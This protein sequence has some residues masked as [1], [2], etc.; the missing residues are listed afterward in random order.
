LR[1]E[2]FN[3]AGKTVL[4]S[5]N[6]EVHRG[7]V[8][9]TETWS[10][11]KVHIVVGRMN[12]KDGASVTVEAGT[13]VKFAKNSWINTENGTTLTVG[14]NTT[15]TRL[16]DDTV[17]GD[18]NLDGGNSVPQFGNAYIRGNGN[19]ELGNVTMK[20]VTTT[21]SGTITQSETWYAGVYHVTGD[22]TVA[23]GATLTLMPG[24]I[25][26]FDPGCQ[27]TVNS[28][29]TLNAKG[30][31]VQPIVFTSVKDDS[32]GGDTN[33]DENE[34]EAAA[35]DWIGLWVY[36]LADMEHCILQYAGPSNERG[37][38]QVSS[39]GIANLN[40]C[41][42]AHAKYDGFWNWGG[43][44]DSKN[45]IIYDVGLATAPYRGTQT[46]TNCTFDSVS[47]FA[48]YWSHWT[49]KAEYTNCIFNNI[50]E[51]WIDNQE[52]NAYKNSLTFRNNVFGTQLAAFSEVGKNGNIWADP[53]FRDAA[54]G[55][56]HL[57][58]GS[59][60]I[61]AADGSVALKTDKSGIQRV[62][63]IY[64]T[65][66]GIAD[67]DGNY[68]DIGAFEFAEGTQG[69]IDLE[70]ISAAGPQSVSIG[71]KVTISWTLKNNGT[72][73]A[74]GVWTDSVYLV[75][76]G[77]QKVLASNVSH[78]GNITSGDLQTFYA[79]VTIPQIA[80]GNWYIAVEAN[81]S[82]SLFEG[83]LIENNNIVS[84]AATFVDVP[85]LTFPTE[86]I[87]LPA[88]E[89]KLYKVIIP[90]NEEYYLVCNTVQDDKSDYKIIGLTARDGF[91]PT[92]TLY[93]WKSST[94]VNGYTKT[95]ESN[96]QD[97]L[98]QLYIPAADHERTVYLD[99]TQLNGLDAAIFDIARIS[100]DFSLKRVDMA[101][102]SVDINDIPVSR[103]VSYASTV[104]VRVAGT[105]FKEGMTAAL[106]PG[107]RTCF[108]PIYGNIMLKEAPERP[109]IY[110]SKVNV[111][112]GCEA[113]LTFEM[114]A[115]GVHCDIND[116]YHL[117]LN[118]NGQSVQLEN[119][120]A[121]LSERTTEYINQKYFSLNA[122]LQIPDSVR[123]GRVYTGYINYSNRYMDSIAPLLIVQASSNVKL[124][125]DPNSWE[126]ASNSLQLL[127]I[128]NESEAGRLTTEDSGRIPFY[129]ITSS[130]TSD[131]DI[132]LGCLTYKDEEACL[133]TTYFTTWKEYHEA[134]AEAA[135]RLNL[136][137]KTYVDTL[138][139]YE[140]AVLMKQGMDANAISGTLTNELTGEAMANMSLTASW[141]D[142][143][144][145]SHSRVVTTDTEGFFSVEYLPNNVTVTMNCIGGTALSKTVFQVKNNDINKQKLTVRPTEAG[146]V[147]SVGTYGNVTAYIKYQ[148]GALTHNKAG[149]MV[150]VCTNTGSSAVNAPM[151]RLQVQNKA[152]KENALLTL[153]PNLAGKNYSVSV[154]PEGFANS[155]GIIVSGK[156]AGTIQPGETVEIPIYWGGLLR[157]WDSLGSEISLGVISANLEMEIDLKELEKSMRPDGIHDTVWNIIW[158]RFTS[159]IGT[160]WGSYVAALGQIQKGL[161]AN[162]NTVLDCA[163]L[164]QLLLAWA[165]DM[166]NPMGTLTS[167]LDSEV[168]NDSNSLTWERV[169][170]GG[171]LE[172]RFL[173]SEMGRGWYHN[174]DYSLTLED[175]GNVLLEF[176]QGIAIVY[177]VQKTANGKTIYY[178]Q[179]DVHLDLVKETDGTWTLTSQ[180]G[181]IYIFA[182]DGTL[183]KITD[184]NGN[185]ISMA[186]SEGKL[187]SV[188][189]FWGQSLTIERNA[190]GKITSVT[191]SNGRRTVYTYDKTNTYLISA[192]WHDGRTVSYEYETAAGNTLSVL[193]TIT[194][195]DGTH[196][197][198]T[199]DDL[200]RVYETHYDNGL[201]SVRYELGNTTADLLT[202]KVYS[203]SDLQGTV[204]L[205]SLGLT[206]KTVDAQGRTTVYL[207]DDKGQLIQSVAPDSTIT[208]YT[209]DEWGNLLSVTDAAGSLLG[210]TYTETGDLSTLTDA[211]GNKTL[212]VYDQFGNMTSMQRA[213]QTCTAYT[214]NDDGTVHTYT[215]R[216]G[217]TFVYSYTVSSRRITRNYMTAKVMLPSRSAKMSVWKAKRSLSPKL[218]SF[219]IPTNRS[220]RTSGKTPSTHS[221]RPLRSLKPLPIQTAV[222]LSCGAVT[223]HIPTLRIMN[224][225]F[226]ET[227]AS[228]NSF[229]VT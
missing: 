208:S 117:Q 200:G 229:R 56:H 8:T 183:S 142:A 155:L 191:E 211:A 51:N 207:Y 101:V 164:Q 37:L 206:A 44:I 20:F 49:G 160:T 104:S 35:G 131:E 85:T 63:D 59:P 193:K 69:N 19:F 60:C 36:G 212:F 167:S 143:Q 26:K 156:T 94:T 13:V 123:A 204:Y 1:V 175:N 133:D 224:S 161:A 24:V 34:T 74:K 28:G 170:A 71:D 141:T 22:L 159:I 107:L 98:T 157:P 138:K 114:P 132:S 152:G 149:E 41:T 18:T 39:N 174:W 68:A 126:D 209:Y 103:T 62:A 58:A 199:Y 31:N 150:L 196:Q 195:A 3:A 140:L 75:S 67:S 12:L 78:S 61:D 93:D 65:P 97:T 163:Q 154:L 146:M 6:V 9:E 83:S 48:M 116:H 168:R 134:L 82:R 192:A 128:G 64:S 125:L 147:Y 30:N 225:I 216:M 47:Y 55:D 17:G 120:I 185:I 86:S 23:S 201:G 180:D 130:D 222:S 115:L 186:Y 172:E 52:S 173:D 38:L 81:T 124:S 91:V 53:L 203:G 165:T 89:S 14:D 70:I 76:E 111:I 87:T 102:G 179:A 217:Q 226:P 158:S 220:R 100:S 219:L 228:W 16:E 33:E 21:T 189:D 90:A 121:A 129:F 40:S 119:S 190:A 127:G 144:G 73:A 171:M 205:N 46:F 197:Y 194:F 178:T 135:T 113:I 166:V 145:E 122:N 72:A 4:N 96:W 106:I 42:L 45:C 27:L 109:V 32:Y 80:S 202:Y 99:I 151:V 92:D 112:S 214:Y 10:K 2:Y 198:F 43:S 66:T 139:A 105:G 118:L 210:Y 108:V 110:A 137:G 25:L 176:P 188:T 77:G 11:D 153:D 169:Y 148:N 221:F 79:E 54:N 215:T 177:Q 223:M 218:R 181:F 162:G 136:R 29:A 84:A 5:A 182:A 184:P 88:K 50:L 7:T 15:F 227:A 187:A 57:M 213:D 95:N